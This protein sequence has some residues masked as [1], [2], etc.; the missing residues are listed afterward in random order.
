MIVPMPV[1]A[2]GFG[3]LSVL[4]PCILPVIPLIAA[5]STK[6]SKLVPPMIG[7]GLSISFA[8]MGVLASAFG[9]VF[10]HYKLVLQVAGGLLIIFLGLCMIFEPLEH[11]VR[12]LIPGKGFT[13]RVHPGEAGNAGG[14]MLGFS[15]GIVW[16]PCIGPMLGAILT[17]VAVEGDIL[18]GAFLLVIYSLGL[19]VPLLAIAYTTRFTLKPFVRY[20]MQIKRVSGFI[21][22]I[23]GLYFLYG[24]SVYAF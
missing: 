20:S 5:Y 1:V 18:Y 3:L 9:S 19:V 17:I 4:S 16:T 7:I 22:V 11:K 12:A 15:L 21:L 13:G 14:L 6:S 2:F 10:Q 24:S 23:M 8:L